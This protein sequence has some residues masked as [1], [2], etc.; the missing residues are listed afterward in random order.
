MMVLYSPQFND[1]STLTYTFEGDKITATLDGVVEV[2]DF[3]GM[4]EGKADG[5][6]VEFLPFNPIGEVERVNG[7][8]KVVLL[9][10]I[11]ADA[12]EAEKFPEWQ[13]V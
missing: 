1:R 7:V 9:N 8:L 2:F 13:E 3:T 4:P 5:I 10:F 11:G 12:T 6:E